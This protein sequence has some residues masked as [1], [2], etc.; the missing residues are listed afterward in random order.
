GRVSGKLKHT[1]LACLVPPQVRTKARFM[2]VHRLFTWADRVLKLSPAGGAKAGSTLA[3]LRACL[4]EFP[5]CKALLKH[6]RADAEG[7]LACQKMLKTTGLSHDTLA[8]CEPLIDAMPSAAVRREFRASLAFELESATTLGLDHIGVPISSES[9]AS[10]FGVAKQHGVGQ[11]QA[12]ARRALH[13]PALCG[14]PTREA[15][16]QVLAVSV[17]TQHEITGQF[18]SLTKQR[19]EVWGHP[20]RLESLRRHQGDPQGERMP[21]PKYQ[22]NYQIIKLAPCGRTVLVHHVP[23]SLPTSP[24]NPQ[25]CQCE[26]S[27]ELFPIPVSAHVWGD[28][29]AGTITP[30]LD[31][32]QFVIDHAITWMPH[33]PEHHLPATP[34]TTERITP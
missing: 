14:V 29:A 16:E 19:H 1:I 21:R 28:T 26:L 8:Q 27:H 17:A 5:A 3:R 13:L 10:L 23:G 9:I 6:F 31:L 15:A 22:S 33:F 25:S 11:T 4:D 18:I 20:E 32:V 7:L 30:S 24:S 12:A 2:N 34:S